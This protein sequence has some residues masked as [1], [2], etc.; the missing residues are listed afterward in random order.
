MEL[1]TSVQRALVPACRAVMRSSSRRPTPHKHR[2]AKRAG[3]AQRQAIVGPKCAMVRITHPHNRCSPPPPP[4]RLTCGPAVQA[5]FAPLERAGTV[6][7]A[8]SG[9][10]GTVSAPCTDSWGWASRAG[11]R[12]RA[13]TGR[14]LPLADE[15][16]QLLIDTAA[17]ADGS[18][19]L[20]QPHPNA[21]CILV[22]SQGRRVGKAFQWAQVG[23]GSRSLRS[24]LAACL[25][26]VPAWGGWRTSELRP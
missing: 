22:D 11:G 6:S 2:A 25:A 8:L 12:R 20:T 23:G 15:D 24:L 13:L 3:W 10:I 1:G 18:M 7:Q 19:G 21:A 4:L 17:L 9:E 5:R 26:W 16:L 14:F